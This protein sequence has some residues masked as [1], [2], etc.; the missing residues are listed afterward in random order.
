LDALG[1]QRH[2]ILLHEEGVIGIVCKAIN[3]W[4]FLG[5]INREHNMPFAKTYTH[6]V[7]LPPVLASI[8]KGYAEYHAA[9]RWPHSWV[10]ILSV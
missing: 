3:R 7:G 6:L 5:S 1:D 2:A 4:Q 10:N 8:L 9:G